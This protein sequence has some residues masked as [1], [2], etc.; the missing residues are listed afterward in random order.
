M[1]CKFGSCKKHAKTEL[2]KKCMKQTP[3]EIKAPKRV[4]EASDYR[5]QGYSDSRDRGEGREKG[6]VGVS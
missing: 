3:K 4:S 1:L 6:C 2:C 5:P